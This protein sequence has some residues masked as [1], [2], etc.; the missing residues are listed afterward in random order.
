MPR[1]LAG[2]VEL[3]PPD[4]WLVNPRTDKLDTPVDE[5]GL[6]DV[7]KLI[8]AVKATIDP[9]Y[10]WRLA[11]PDV[12]H[13]YWKQ[14]DYP[15]IHLPSGVNPR[16]FRNL[17]IHKGLL[18]REFHNWIHLVTLPPAVPDEEVMLYHTEAYNAA[19]NLFQLA[20]TT[21]HLERVAERGAA[22]VGEASTS[23]IPEPSSLDAIGEAIMQETFERNFYRYEK[24][25]ER[26]TRIP[27]KFHLAKIEPFADRHAVATR[28]GR[29]VTFK[30]INLIGMVAP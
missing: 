30:E 3:P 18:P 12:H 8:T 14:G 11:R 22:R 15:F 1:R 24:E 7:D 25:Y 13:F 29:F 6:V 28:L 4:A 23:L 17:P 21:V 19:K 10:E 9:S 20:R 2:S 16:D 27:E 5:R 26:A